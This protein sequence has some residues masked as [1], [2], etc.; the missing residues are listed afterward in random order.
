MVEALAVEG[1]GRG[2][3]EVEQVADDVVEAGRLLFHD[4]DQGAGGA[5]D[6]VA[7]ELAEGAQR[8][9]EHAEGVPDLVGDDGGELAQGGEALALDEL[10]LGAGQ[11]GVAPAQIGEEALGVEG[12]RDLGAEEAARGQVLGE[13]EGGHQQEQLGRAP[14][15]VVADHHAPLELG[16]A[17]EQDAAGPRPPGSCRKNW[18]ID[19]RQVVDV[20]AAL[21]PGELGRGA[22]HA[23]E[24]AGGR[25]AG[26][27]VEALDEIAGRAE[28]ED[29]GLAGGGGGCEADHPHAQRGDP[30]GEGLEQ[31]LLRLLELRRDPELRQGGELLLVEGA[32]GAVGELEDHVVAV[33]GDP[34][35]H[36]AQR[37]VTA[38]DAELVRVGHG[39]AAEAPLVA[40]AHAIAVLGRDAF[41]EA[42]ALEPLPRQ[43]HQIEQR[44]VGV[45]EARR[46]EDAAREVGAVEPGGFHGGDRRRGAR[47][48]RR[49]AAC[50]DGIPPPFGRRNYSRAARG[51]RTRARR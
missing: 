14:A 49:G 18:R 43:A 34:D 45:H 51:W 35:L 19:E 46:A 44:L 50:R 48:W 29:A 23:G 42:P 13:E 9:E 31:A 27:G 6:I 24:H 16:G 30:A 15:G 12:G 4:L 39:L 10:L 11:V 20:G 40:L 8:V 37:A 17:G 3:G 33:R 36:R 38:E 41:E 32:V 25:G 2:A 1:G 5:L 21:A 26:G 47:L 7:E 28:G 22:P